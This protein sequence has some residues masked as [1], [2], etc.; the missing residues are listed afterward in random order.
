MC[1]WGGGAPPIGVSRTGQASMRPVA[2]ARRVFNAELC[3][4]HCAAQT[5]RTSGSTIAPAMRRAAPS[6]YADASRLPAP[7]R[8]SSHQTRPTAAGATAVS[9]RGGSGVRASGGGVP[10]SI[11]NPAVF[12]RLAAGLASVE[13]SGERRGPSPVGSQPQLRGADTGGGRGRGRK[14]QRPAWARGGGDGPGSETEAAHLAELLNGQAPPPPEQGHSPARWVRC[15]GQEMFV[16]LQMH[17]YTSL[18]H[19]DLIPLLKA[20]PHVSSLASPLQTPQY[21]PFLDRARLCLQ[22]THP[23][24]SQQRHLP[25]VLQQV[26]AL[27]GR[28]WTRP[29]LHQQASSAGGASAP[30]L[31]PIA[32]QRNTAGPLIRLPLPLAPAHTGSACGSTAR[33]CPRTA[34]A[35]LAP[36]GPTWASGRR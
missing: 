11:R 3:S 34:S 20:L 21:V 4:S 8:A 1:V 24:P 10:S 35:N 13:R 12:D 30:S 29:P 6:P 22:Q 18:S 23:R 7:Q 5:R 16:A 2:S 17:L 19:W 31:H 9:G 32:P 25:P 33:T 27:M 26:G 28:W 36:A 15:M 14:P